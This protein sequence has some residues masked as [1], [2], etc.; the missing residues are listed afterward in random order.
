MPRPRC[1]GAHGDLPWQS[2]VHA[3]PC[4][5]T[6][7]CHF[8]ADHWRLKI[9]GD[10]GASVGTQSTRRVEPAGSNGVDPD[11]QRRWHSGGHCFRKRCEPPPSA[12]PCRAARNSNGPHGDGPPDHRAA[13]A[14]VAG[15]VRK[16]AASTFCL[17]K[18]RLTS[19]VAACLQSDTNY[20]QSI[21]RTR[22]SGRSLAMTSHVEAV[23]GRDSL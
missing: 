4:P 13:E 18:S 7:R 11:C 14:P 10:P 12:G 1:C 21:L 6:R 15:S 9:G 23:R 22:L 3:R 17:R 5:L 2:S 8:P 19:L 16:L 20:S